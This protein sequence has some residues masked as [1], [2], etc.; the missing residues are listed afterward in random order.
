LPIAQGPP[1]VT[2]AVE[3]LD[4]VAK[5]DNIVFAGD[6]ADANS[7]SIRAIGGGR[8]TEAQVNKAHMNEAHMNEAHATGWFVSAT[9]RLPA[10]S[11]AEIAFKKYL[12]SG[13]ETP[14]QIHAC[15]VRPAEAE[16]KLSEG[17]LGSK[18]KRVVM[19][20]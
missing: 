17:L 12:Q 16:I 3:A 19:Q 8:F 20:E 13:G 18:I 4:R 9:N 2:T 10:E 7:D 11:I 5:I 14:E 15:Y 6:W 1:V